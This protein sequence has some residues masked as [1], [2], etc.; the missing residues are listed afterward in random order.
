MWPL[1]D[2]QIGRPDRKAKN[3]RAPRWIPKRIVVRVAR[4]VSFHFLRQGIQLTDLRSIL[5]GL[6][7][8][9]RPIVI[10][11]LSTDDEWAIFEPLLTTPCSRGGRPPKNPSEQIETA[12]VCMSG[13]LFAGISQRLIRWP[14]SRRGQLSD[15]EPRL[16][17][18]GPGL[19]GG[20]CRSAPARSG[21]AWPI[22][23]C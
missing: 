23:A 19:A 22:S 7:V 10:R 17:D 9:S 3:Q 16:G 11:G 4:F 12:E 15:Q 6:L 18:G 2:A 21:A 13:T 8:N 1:G 5:T 14:R 20:P